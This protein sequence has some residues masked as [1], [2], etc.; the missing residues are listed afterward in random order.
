LV[1]DPNLEFVASPALAP[2]EVQMDPED[3]KKY[4]QE[5]VIA[6]NSALPDEDDDL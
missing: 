5:L 4:E 6:Q 3:I 2:P 1:G